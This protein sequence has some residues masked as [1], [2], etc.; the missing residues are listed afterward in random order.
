MEII[1]KIRKMLDAG[2]ISKEDIERAFPQ[3]KESDDERVRLEIHAYLFNTLH[4]TQQLTPRTNE[5]ERWLAYLEKQKESLHIPET[6]KENADSFTGVQKPAE[7]S[8]TDA[9]FIEEIDETL[10]M[11][12][13]GRN[14]VVKNQIERERNW[15]EA[16]P[17]RFNLQ[18]KQEWSEEEKK[19]LYNAIEAVKYAYDISE[20]TS[21]FKCV[22][23]L[24]SLRP[25]PHWKPSEAQLDALLAS[26]TKDEGVYDYYALE[27]LYNDLKKLL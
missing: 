23:F 6:C 13:T 22:K 1:E 10:F 18:P 14:E 12:E 5:L 17:E 24:K 3:L 11:A 7:W 27:S 21:G 26:Y 9:T 16:L 4:N 2:I 20:G 15:L 25:Q 19:H 8:L